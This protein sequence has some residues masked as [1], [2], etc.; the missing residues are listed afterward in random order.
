MSGFESSLFAGMNLGRS[1]SSSAERGKEVQSVGE[2]SA[3]N[4]GIFGV[5]KPMLQ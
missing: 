4:K 3:E 2:G 1:K 5:L